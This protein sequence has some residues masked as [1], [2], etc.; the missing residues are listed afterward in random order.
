MSLGAPD[1]VGI[2]VPKCGTTWWFD[3]ILRH[4]DIYV[5]NDKELS[6]FNWWFLVHL[7]ADGCTQA[8]LDAYRRWFPR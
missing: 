1:F 5:H 7:N 3:L 6:F 8:D 2:G 4:P